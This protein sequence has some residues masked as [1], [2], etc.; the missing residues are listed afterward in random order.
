VTTRQAFLVVVFTAIAQSAVHREVR[1]VVSSVITVI[2][3]C[4]AIT[5][6]TRRRNRRQDPRTGRP[7]DDRHP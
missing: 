5:L 6:Y 7:H 2:I 3:L 4:V 1:P